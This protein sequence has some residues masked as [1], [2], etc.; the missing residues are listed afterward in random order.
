MKKVTILALH[1]GYGGIEKCITSL[2]NSLCDEYNVEIIS[3]YKLDNSP[4]FPLNEKI[5]VKYLLPGDIVK[6]VEKYKIDLRQFH[7]ISLIKN[8]FNDYIRKNNIKELFSD[9]K[10]SYKNIKARKKKMIDAIRK[11]DSDIIISTRDIHNNWLGKYGKSKLK[12]GWEHNYHN[13][14]NKYINKVISSIKNLDYFV[15]VTKEQKDFYQKLT[16]TKCVYIPNGIEVK[17]DRFAEL[18]NNNL[19]SIGRLSKEKGFIDLIDII[20]YVKEVYPNVKLNLIGDGPERER[21]EKHVKLLG[22]EN[23]VVLQGYKNTGE[24]NELLLDSSIYVMTSFSESFGLVLLE[25]AQFRIPLVAFKNSGSN[26]IISNN[27]DGYLIE[28]RNKE[29]MAKK[30][31]ELLKNKNRRIIMGNNAYKKCMKYELSNIIKEWKKLIER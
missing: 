19:I 11:C 10:L 25:A 31:I 6:K 4:V 17:D 9:I 14:N 24:I 13:N 26:E 22:L 21:I 12:I 18:D 1:L 20:S 28:N 16:K 23:N 15:L 30:I 8:I 27:W 5:K 29:M 2:A 3:T 7:F